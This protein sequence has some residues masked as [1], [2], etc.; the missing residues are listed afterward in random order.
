MHELC[1]LKSVKFLSSA[2]VLLTLIILVQ[3]LFTIPSIKENWALA[4][5]IKPETF[6]ELYFENHLAL[7]TTAVKEQSYDFNFTIHNLENKDMQYTY[8]M[9]IQ[10]GNQKQ[11]L[12]KKTVF[13]KNNEYKTITEGFKLTEDIERARIVINLINK[14]QEIAFWI[15]N[16]NVDITM[17]PAPSNKP[18]SNP[19]KK[20]YGAW[21]WRSDVNRSLLWLGTDK[22]GKDI[23]SD[24]FPA[25]TIKITK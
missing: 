7:P 11:S 2:I 24:K 19:Q 8:N 17:T 25:P 3:Y 6:T 1:R 23:W 22:D 18:Q 13:I 21:Y 9:Y 12:D 4:T 16:P 5:T 15:Q 20:Q 14:N 10:I